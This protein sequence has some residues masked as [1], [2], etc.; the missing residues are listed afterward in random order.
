MSWYAALGALEQGLVYGIMA[1]GVYLTFRILDFPDLTVDG[2]LPLGAS[3]TALA[4]TSGINPFI[5]LLLAGFGGFLAG[6]VTAILN[7]KL[8]VLH[9]LASILTMI[10]LYSINIRIMDGPNISLLATDTVFD[11]LINFGVP[12]YLASTMFFVAFAALIVVGVIWFL[13]TEIGLSLLATGDNPQMITA[14]GVNTHTIIILGVGL[15]N[16]LVA[17]AGSLIA[18]NQGAADVNMG[19][20]TIIAGLASVI[21]GETV[22][23]DKTIPRAIIAVLVGSVIYRMAIALALGLEM[24]RFSVNPSD[25]NLITALLVIIALTAPTIK[26]KLKKV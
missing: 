5:A 13:Y 1:I 2:S 11:P 10:A 17:L 26:K 21:V 20:G 16:A 6:M 12:G 18:Q 4:L 14:Q 22:F 9:L 7:T 3:I 23:G 25:L 19:V 8:K 15:S 24:G